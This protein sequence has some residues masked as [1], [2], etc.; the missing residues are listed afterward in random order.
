MKQPGA[1][2]PVDEAAGPVERAGF[3]ATMKAVLWA[4]AGIRKRSDYGRDARSLDPRAVIAAGVLGGIV[5]VLTL[6][7]IV[8]LVVG[9]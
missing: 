1:R 7:M 9:A 3:L 4:F 6:V 5:F 2:Q 8:R